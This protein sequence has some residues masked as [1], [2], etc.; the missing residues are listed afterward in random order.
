M[1]S[2]I[3]S[4]WHSLTVSTVGMHGGSP[5][6]TDADSLTWRNSRNPSN[7]ARMGAISILVLQASRLGHRVP[8]SSL[9]TARLWLCVVE[10]GGG[11]ALLPSSVDRADGVPPADTQDENWGLLWEQGATDGCFS[12]PLPGRHPRGRSLS[13]VLQNGSWLCNMC[14]EMQPECDLGTGKLS[15]HPW[16]R[17]CA[18]FL[19]RA[20]GRPISAQ[21]RDCTTFFS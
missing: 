7:R 12:A 20:C 13:V 14:S 1:R 4:D 19:S 3:C 17:C 10:L 2:F 15:S 9:S 21:S 11:P 8:G 18:G 16:H 6:L 5:G